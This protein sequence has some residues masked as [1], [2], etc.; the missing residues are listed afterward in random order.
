MHKRINCYGKFGL[1]TR[2]LVY[3]VSFATG[4]LALSQNVLAHCSSVA[5]QWNDF[6]IFFPLSSS[7]QHTKILLEK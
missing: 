3:L 2:N 4:S 7:F 1:L 5:V 6:K